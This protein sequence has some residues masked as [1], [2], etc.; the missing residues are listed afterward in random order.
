[1]GMR[2]FTV[3]EMIIIITAIGVLLTLG[4]IGL[5]SSQARSRDNQRS[6]N[7]TSIANYFENYYSSNFSYPS[8][9]VTESEDSITTAMPEIDPKILRAPGVSSGSSLEPATNTTQTTAGVTPLPT[10]DQYV[11][12]PLKADGSLCEAISD[13]CRTFNLYYRTELDNTVHMVLSRS[14]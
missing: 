8:L 1:M 4:V 13:T 6:T 5:Q 2:G 3:M 10:A 9:E 14:Q 12:Q 7:A 11:Y